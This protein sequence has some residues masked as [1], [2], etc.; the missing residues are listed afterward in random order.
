LNIV[1]S[2][3]RTILALAVLAPLA[4]RAATL[5]VPA[6]FPTIQGAVDAAASGDLVLVAPGTYRENV[7]VSMKNVSLR[8]TGGKGVTV[9]DGGGAG[10]VV[11]YQG[12][13]AAWVWVTA[14][15]EGF[16]ISNGNYY[17]GGGVSSHRGTIE[18]IDCLIQGNHASSGGGV[19]A[20]DAGTVTLT[21]STVSG[22]VAD[23]AGGG[24][25]GTMGGVVVTDSVVSNNRAGSYGGG[26]AGLGYCGGFNVTRS[27]VTGNTASEG[28]GL[29]TG[30]G[31]GGCD[32][33]GQ[34]DD[35][36]IARNVATARGGGLA[37]RPDGRAWINGSTFADNVAPEAGSFF[38]TD[39][40][41]HTVT[42]TI[43][44]GNGTPA[45]FGHV[46]Q[47]PS[48]PDSVTSSII[49]LGVSTA[50]FVGDGTNLDVDPLFVNAA[51]GDYRL[52]AG[53]PAIDAGAAASGTDVTGMAR[54]QGSGPDIGAYEF[55]STPPAV[56]VTLSGTQGLN[57]WYVSDV[58][59]T[60][61]ASDTG[62]GVQS[63]GFR[64]P[65]AAST[66]PGDTVALM[67]TSDGATP[68][69]TWATDK[70]GNV[71]A[72]ETTAV[73]IDR[74]APA[75]TAKLTGTL[76]SNGWYRSTVTVAVTATDAASGV[77]AVLVAVDAAPATTT[78]GAT[79]STTVGQTAGSTVSYSA[80]DKAGHASATGLVT[81]KVDTTA[82]ALTFS[83][84]PTTVRVT[85]KNA[86]VKAS[87]A[88]TDTLS[89]VASAVVRVTDAKGKLVATTT[90]GGTVNVLAAK[91]A[92]YTFTATATDQAGNA[93]VKTATVTV[94]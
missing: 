14:S 17:Y 42:N 13:Y 50:G 33:L 75:A 44:W 72:E 27:F 6:D 58:S 19:Y 46:S 45:V 85:N 52:R 12:S 34:V 65:A 63:V 74:T 53:S 77:A 11:T 5:N 32:T 22:N 82:P 94:Q 68:L 51:G 81:V 1:H 21:R 40:T 64:L 91:G 15:L 66:V 59:A 10:S 18:V 48:S 30:F 16:T 26:L 69:V 76:G 62:V 41:W 84:S 49:E 87:G 8:S 88:V 92:K 80:V 9:L 83:V 25:Y 70:N 3:V 57:G 86:A 29:F 67:L 93:A 61:M 20:D 28:G 37:M 78:A 47:F 73:A 2:I 23:Y 35:S 7:V 24:G 36:V 56:A 38:S 89:G 90:L 39:R 71:S 4:A 43:F 79:A 54:P 55:D 31:Y 60:V